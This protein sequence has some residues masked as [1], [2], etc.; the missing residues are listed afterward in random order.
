MLKLYC[1]P[2]TISLAVVTALN[3]GVHWEAIRVDFGEAE[4]TK[5]EYLSINPKGRVPV[6][7]TPEGALTETGAILEY[8]G[9]TA[10]PN[11][12]PV[13][14]LQ[15]ARMR[16]EMYYLGTSMHVNHAHKMRGYRWADQQSSYDD[17]QAKVPETMTASC[18]YLEPLIVGP[19][20]FGTEPTLADFYLYPIAT[21]LESDGV[22]V[23]AFPK[24]A[25]WKAAMEARASVQ[26]AISDGFTG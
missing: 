12:V 8:L 20:L 25:D 22:N 23:A 6:L 2:K 1:A 10:L 5:P 17:M 7:V 21:W 24:L 4:Q 9:E 19:Y 15:R 18:A 16:E 13:D 14:P 26:K 3:E 11:L